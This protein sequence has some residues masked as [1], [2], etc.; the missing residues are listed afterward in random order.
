MVITEQ[1]TQQIHLDST[2]LSKYAGIYEQIRPGRAPVIFTVTVVEDQLMIEHPLLGKIPMS[3]R[4][5]NAFSM[6]GT[7]IE[8]VSDDHGAVSH[9]MMHGVEGDMKAVRK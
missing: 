2:P 9:L 7:L 4:S 3:I 1:G 5:E 6:L 8:F